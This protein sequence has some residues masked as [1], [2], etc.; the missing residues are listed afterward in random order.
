MSPSFALVAA[1]LLAT[2]APLPE[3]VVEAPGPEG[4][5]KGKMIEVKGGPVALIIPGSGP[6]DLDGN[7]P[8]G[9]TAAT[10][11]LLAEE[12]AK[13]GIGTVR[14]DKRGMFSSKAAFAD[15][16]AVTMG[17]YVADIRSWTKAVKKE[18]GAP[19]VWLIGHS[20]GG[21]V[22]LLAAKEI[23]DLCGLV[24]A[25]APGRPLGN[26]LREQLKAN[27]AN[28]PVLEQ[29]FGAL[30]ALEKGERVDTA[31]LHPGLL[32]LFHPKV[33]GFL[34]SFMAVDPAK[35][36]AGQT[37]PVLI[38]QGA[39]DLQVKQ[40]DAQRLAAANPKAKL[41]MLPK[42]T[43]ALKE[44]A[45][46]TPEASHATHVDSSLPIAPGVVDAISTFIKAH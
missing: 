5:L 40:A 46:D 36:I 37:K 44:A 17:D 29:A 12:L 19:C 18:T 21:V 13:R 42:V 23:P 27:S 2:V 30:A 39:N 45:S 10:Y 15:A 8:L 33:Q 34:I 11:R 22:A 41:V 3:R 25:A 38:V 31:S 9:V 7:N 28:A 24:L 1:A 32:Q 6:T 4:P 14:I 16:N 43:H 20:E 26:V 35:T